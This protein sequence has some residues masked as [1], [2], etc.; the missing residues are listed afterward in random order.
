MPTRLNYLKRPNLKQPVLVAGL[1]GI[2]HIGKLAVEYLIHQLSAKK[3]A[4]LYSD[5]FPEWVVRDNGSVKTLKVDLSYC[6]LDG[7]KRDLL[8]ATADAQAASPAG[9]YRLTGEIL[10]VAA[11]HGADTVVTMAAYVLSHNE[12]R[13]KVVGAASD[14]E[15]VKLLRE[16]GVELLD[17]GMIVGMN[18]L[19]PGLAAARGMHGFC[20]L[21]TTRGGLLD[22]AATGS[23][24]Q[25]LS[26]VLGFKLDLEELHKH[27]ATL[28]KFR[29]PKL[30]LPSGIEEEVSYIR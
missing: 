20:L 11:Q 16:R 9:Q 26:E 22:V 23:V 29:P 4:E 21:G 30:R 12:A 27:A 28:P 7:L 8:L 17:S 15:T 6:T 13:A 1:P 19:L 2:A 3:F 10:D 18:G 5:H 14:V 25:A 24:I